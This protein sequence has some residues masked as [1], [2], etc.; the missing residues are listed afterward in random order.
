MAG[1]GQDPLEIPGPHVAVTSDIWC[2]PVCVPLY[3][4]QKTFPTHLRTL[5]M[6]PSVPFADLPKR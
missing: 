3:L 6:L 2:V 5:S 4:I 1:A